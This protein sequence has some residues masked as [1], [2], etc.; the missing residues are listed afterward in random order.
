MGTAQGLFSL[1]RRIISENAL[2]VLAE[3]RVD[4]RRLLER[5][6]AGDW[7]VIED[8][9]W[10]LNR[11]AVDAGYGCIA[12]AYIVLGDVRVVLLTQPD[13]SATL[14]A[15]CEEIRRLQGGRSS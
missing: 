13:R 2:A 11:M 7:G 1:G 6:A 8:K 12:S 9:S 10:Y 3:A 15:L 4:P 14:I 5:H